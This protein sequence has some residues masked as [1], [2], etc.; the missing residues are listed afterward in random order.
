[1]AGDRLAL[2]GAFAFPLAQGSQ[3]FFVEQA[4]ALT[5]AG[6]RPRLLV[7]GRGQGAQPSDLEVERIARWVSPRAFGSGPSWG[8]P[9][10]D[11]ALLARYLCAVGRERIECTLAHNAEAAYI[12]LAARP[13]C[14]VPVIYVAHTILAHELSAYGPPAAAA[15]LD[16]LGNA[17]DRTIAQ[18][19]DG[20]IALSE[21]ARDTLRGCSDTPLA[22]LPPG[23]DCRPAPVAAVCGSVCARHGPV[24]D[25]FMLYSGNRA[26]YQELARLL[27][28]ARPL[29]AGL[30]PLLIASHGPLPDGASTGAAAVEA[31][32]TESVR[33]VRVTDF[34]EMRTLCHSARLALLARRRPGGFPIKLLN[35]MEAS[36]PI[37]AWRSAA[38][39]LEHGRSAWLL[40][41]G[42]GPDALASAIRRLLADRS[43]CKRLGCAARLQ[44]EQRHGW[45]ALA[46]ATLDFARR[47]STTQRPSAP[48]V[49]A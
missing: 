21:S 40:E 14:A 32:A 27:A 9:V 13:F 19:A 17:I 26:R 25:P 41:D 46:A 16:R 12:A 6:A 20:V 47:C 48:A 7:Y 35:Y 3:V 8:K 39:G 28:A 44:L 18:R 43:L 10:A 37:L 45:S 22:L 15:L 2:L 36:R 4:R 29:P 49:R 34:E 23:L 11:A 1:M 24:P 42:D 30:P 38:S 5:A 31:I 33:H